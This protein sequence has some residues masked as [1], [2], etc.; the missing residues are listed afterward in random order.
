MA[1]PN[2]I[3]R[4]ITEAEFL[5]TVIELAQAHH[6][7][8]AHFRPGM[9][10]RIDKKG[11]PVWVTPIRGDGKGYPDLTL[12]RRNRNN[13]GGRL[14]FCEIKSE[15]GRL[16]EEQREWLDLL[17][18]VEDSANGVVECHVWK[19]SDWEKIVKALA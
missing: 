3:D 8:V 13:A 4:F 10:S 5:T 16:S 15:K 6:W 1:H 2:P 9:T 19:P 12:A 11:K 7:R 17:S 18:H 14:L